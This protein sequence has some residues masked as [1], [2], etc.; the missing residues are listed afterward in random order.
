[1]SLI[2]TN[3]YI[4][5][6]KDYIINGISG[7]VGTLISFR[8]GASDAELLHKEFSLVVSE[9]DLLGL[10]NFHTYVKLLIDGN[11]SALFNMHTLLPQKSLR[12]EARANI[13]HLSRKRYGRHREEVE[14]EIQ[15]SWSG[16]Q[17][18]RVIFSESWLREIGE[19]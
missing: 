8:V 14:A 6:L 9:N 7:N 12:P 16:K 15:Q 2:L 1:M 13:H 11:V 18:K 4:A 17:S 3:Q 10:P 19:D 5:Q